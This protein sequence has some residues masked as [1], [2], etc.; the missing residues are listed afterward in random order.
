[1]SLHIV[2]LGSPRGP[3]EGLRV[4]TVRHPPRGVARADFA[5]QN[6]YD[7]RL[8]LLTPSAGLVKEAQ[9]AG[10]ERDWARFAA[11]YLREMAAP[12]AAHAIDLLAALSR[13]TDLAVGCYCEDEIHCHRSTPRALLAERGA[14]LAATDR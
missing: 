2:R 1:M 11:R 13:L 6:G 5:R 12:D 10:S 7:V 9:A 3:H 8:P 14:K 4:G